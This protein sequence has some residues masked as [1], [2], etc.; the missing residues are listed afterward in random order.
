MDQ[1]KET[2]DDAADIPQ[3]LPG[4]ENY[5]SPIDQSDVVAFKYENNIGDEMGDGDKCYKCGGKIIWKVSGGMGQPSGMHGRCSQC[6][7]EY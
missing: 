6:N 7:E 1:D 2:K 3:Q 5:N 4:D